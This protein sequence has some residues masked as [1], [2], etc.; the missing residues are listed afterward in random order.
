MYADAGPPPAIL[1]LRFDNQN[2]EDIDL[3]GVQII[4]CRTTACKTPILLQ[5]F[6]TCTDSPCL[7][8]DQL[9]DTEKN[10]L[11]CTQNRCRADSSPY[12]DGGVRDE[13]HYLRLITQFSDRT[14]QSRSF[15]NPFL[16][17]YNWNNNL[18]VRIDETGLEVMEN[19]DPLPTIY[20]LPEQYGL[21]F[22]LTLFVES[23]V[24]GIIF[25][26]YFRSSV[27]TLFKRILMIVVINSVTFPI[28]W[29]FFPA[30]QPFIDSQAKILGIA[31]LLAASVYALLWYFVF[32]A[33]SIDQTI[34]WIAAL[35]FF[36]LVMIF[37]CFE[38][39][40]W[41]AY[42]HYPVA[43]AKGIP[44]PTILFLAEI[45]TF[46]T[47]AWLLMVYGKIPLKLSLW[48]SLG[49]NMASFFAGLIV[50]HRWY[51]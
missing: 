45:F 50:F 31:I 11:D 36:L 49:M 30:W 41:F 7:Q 4:G 48:L 20:R 15:E 46:A 18:L 19:P 3:E 6:G 5:Q 8:S 16:K 28:V 38:L 2:S 42:Q 44:Y 14:R 34:N 47:E 51:Y 12:R 37:A 33:S 40:M 23:L 39:F 25:F 13:A 21:A 22:L 10:R 27:L 26:I 9:F 32:Q 24:A 29:F 43:S 1:W 35:I 17:G